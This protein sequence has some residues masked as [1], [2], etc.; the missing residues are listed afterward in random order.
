MLKEID[1]N[2]KVLMPSYGAFVMKCNEDDF[3]AVKNQLTGKYERRFSEVSGHIINVKAK[4]WNDGERYLQLLIKDGKELYCIKLPYKF[5]IN[6]AF[7]LVSMNIDFEQPI[8]LQIGKNGRGYDS[9]YIKQNNTWLK[10]FFTKKDPKGMPDWEN[11]DGKW[12]RDKQNLFFEKV[13]DEKIAPKL[14]ELYPM[15][16]EVEKKEETHQFDDLPF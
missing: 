5:S 15:N 11:T 9:L 7:M 4:T 8:S 6:A 3:Q 13:I 12:N 16:E 1:Q 10:H 14:R 2:V